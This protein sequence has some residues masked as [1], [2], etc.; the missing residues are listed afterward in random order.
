MPPMKC[1]Y[2]VLGVERDVEEA[3]IKRA[4]RMAALKW[5]PGAPP[6]CLERLLVPCCP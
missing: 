6:L 3:A 2:E 1:L 4:Y 5:H